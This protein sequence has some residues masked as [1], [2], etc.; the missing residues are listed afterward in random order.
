MHLDLPTI[1][2]KNSYNTQKYEQCS[3]NHSHIFILYFSNYKLPYTNTHR[4]IQHRDYGRRTLDHI[5]SM[6]YKQK[7][8]DLL[9]NHWSNMNGIMLRLCSQAYI[10]NLWECNTAPLQ[11]CLYK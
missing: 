10:S 4:Y 9:G 3:I 2:L 1:P 11:S 7:Y 8:V 5:M 6:I